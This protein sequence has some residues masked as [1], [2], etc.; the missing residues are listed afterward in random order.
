MA[1]ARTAGPCGVS[2]A[3]RCFKGTVGR[4]AWVARATR[5]E[6]PRFAVAGR[7]AGAARGQTPAPAGEPA[8]AVRARDITA[9]RTDR[10]SATSPRPVQVGTNQEILPTGKIDTT[11]MHHRLAQVFSTDLGQALGNRA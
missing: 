5:C 6:E 11:D 3:G 1:R 4:R 8:L 9:S 7:R 2:G 10:R